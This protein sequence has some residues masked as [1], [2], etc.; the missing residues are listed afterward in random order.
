MEIPAIA[1]G[2]SSSLAPRG[3]GAKPDPDAAAH[4]A[5]KAFE[6]SFIAEM[7]KGSGLNEMPSGFGGGE[8]EEAFSS[9]LT[10][11]YAKLMSDRGGLGL[12]EHIFD[13][14]K[15]KATGQ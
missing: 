11:E 1:S 12:A 13:A 9:F 15:Q 6:T 5:A 7:L 3:A 14:L 10:Q 4:S 8:G 2:L